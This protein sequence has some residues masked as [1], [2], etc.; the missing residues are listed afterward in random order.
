MTWLAD[1]FVTNDMAILH[2]VI[3]I[4]LAVALQH[5]LDHTDHAGRWGFVIFFALAA[6]IG[7]RWLVTYLRDSDVELKEIAA[8]YG[9]PAHLAI[10]QDGHDYDLADD[11]VTHLSGE[12]SVVI[13][14][15]YGPD[16][17]RQPAETIDD[18]ELPQRKRF[19]ADLLSAA[20]NR[21]IKKYTRIISF[22]DGGTPFEDRGTPT[23]LTAG[24]GR[25][26]VSCYM[27]QH[28]EDILNELYRHPELSN[29]LFLYTAPAIMQADVAIL[30]PKVAIVDVGG[31]FDKNL[32]EGGAF[33]YYD[34]PNG[35][36]LK[37]LNNIVEIKN[38]YTPVSKIVVDSE[39]DFRCRGVP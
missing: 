9:T 11:T 13:F 14:D 17:S 8:S 7:V 16:G 12:D 37:T 26:H 32:W 30:G 25:E 39:R 22:D 3:V 29:R 20:E 33:F 10:G 31:F 24:Y 23:T 6:Y 4:A 27:A 21:S 19:F 2:D 1:F 35:N 34:P 18:L 38:K 15:Y 36:I 28:A 5:L